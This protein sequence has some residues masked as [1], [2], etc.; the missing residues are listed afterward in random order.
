M[1][2]PAD[3]VLHLHFDAVGQFRPEI[4]VCKLGDDFLDGELPVLAVP[5]HDFIKDDA[6]GVDVCRFL[7]L[8]HYV[9]LVLEVF[10]GSV[11]GLVG[12]AGDEG[13]VLPHGVEAAAVEDHLV[14]LEEAVVGGEAAVDDVVLVESGDG[15]AETDA[16]LDEFCL[17]DGL[18]DEFVEGSGVVP[19]DEVD[20]FPLVEVGEFGEGGDA[21]LVP[22]ADLVFDVLEDVL[23]DLVL[24]YSDYVLP[25]IDAAPLQ[26]PDRLLIL[27]RHHVLQLLEALQPDLGQRL[28]LILPW[29]LQL[30]FQQRTLQILSIVSEDTFF[31]LES[32]RPV[33]QRLHH[34]AP[35]AVHH[36]QPLREQHE[37]DRPDEQ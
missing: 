16:E 10:D 20:D 30:V 33:V 34:R 35:Q 31:V 23:G 17:A 28:L 32:T 3:Q 22:V 21:E 27:L 7:G 24:R 9:V 1:P 2:A 6:E 5:G 11:H 14:L 29:L 36:R 8:E 25:L 12:V 18:V 4:L 19:F 26:D 15:L 37:Q 13:E